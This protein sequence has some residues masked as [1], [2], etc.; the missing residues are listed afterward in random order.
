M[1]ILLWWSYQLKQLFNNFRVLLR[2]D[3]TVTVLKRL[4]DHYFTLIC[5]CSSNLK[6]N[7]LMVLKIARSVK[8][9]RFH[10]L[11]SHFRVSFASLST[12]GPTKYHI[13]NFFSLFFLFQ[14]EQ[15]SIKSSIKWTKNLEPNQNMS[16]K[17]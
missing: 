13:L 10:S 7:V 1:I 3:I 6:K 9:Q 15:P 12:G 4:L 2:K 17:E 5:H 8:A 16:L 11:M 14:A